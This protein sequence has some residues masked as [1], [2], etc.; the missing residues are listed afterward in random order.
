MTAIVKDVTIR[1]SGDVKG[2]DEAS[3]DFDRVNKD[4]GDKLKQTEGSTVS[5]KTQLRGLK[6]ELANAT[7]PK[8]VE[9]LARAAGE[10]ANKIDDASKAARIF[11]TESKFEQVSN[12][13]GGIVRNVASLNFK[14]AAEESRF[15][16]S[17][18]KSMTFKEALGGVKDLGVTLF[19]LG[20]SLLLNPIFL[21]AATITGIGFALYELRNKIPFVTKALD[22]ISES[23]TKI[24]KAVTGFTDAIGLTTTATDAA[25]D[26]LI[27]RGKEVDEQRERR[28]KYLEEENEKNKKIAQEEEERRR[29]KEEAEKK[30]IEESRRLAKEKFD[31]ETRLANERFNDEK[32]KRDDRYQEEKQLN[33]DR[34]ELE[35]NF[36][37]ISK[38]YFEKI[39]E[40][41]EK[42][43]KEDLERTIKEVELFQ[44]ATNA[45]FEYKTQVA[46]VEQQ[47]ADANAEREKARVKQLV[48]SGII[49]EK[50]G[51]KRIKDIDDKAEKERRESARR[52][53]IRDKSQAAFNVG[54]STL[55]AVA[56]EGFITPTAILVAIAGAISL[57][58]VLAKP[59]PQFAD[60]VIDLKGGVKGKDSIHALLMPGESVMTTEETRKNKG[61]LTAIREDKLNEY[62]QRSVIDPELYRLKDEL[63]SSSLS[64]NIANSIKVKADIDE[65]ALG[66]VFR[67]NKSVQISNADYLAAKIASEMN[68]KNNDVGL[69]SK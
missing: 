10:V 49:S 28:R 29:K 7:D 38:K 32:K 25:F 51:S 20:K 67:E 50:E 61:L 66:R 37:E 69:W 22:F 58:S 15:L 35:K 44:Q 24:K 48:E 40:E 21:L 47:E 16:A 17:A 55:V 13:F 33:H 34:I 26:R 1:F 59:I 56:K 31:F 27:K 53:A 4:I 62:L 6:A 11:S 18:I 46:E 65:Y 54:I 68:R 5:L 45:I 3:K 64:S 60:G 23:I 12:A 39:K 52:Q 36:Y 14:Q 42:K 41:E 30:Y 57:L 8:D 63:I 19:N 2:L 43:D 9:R